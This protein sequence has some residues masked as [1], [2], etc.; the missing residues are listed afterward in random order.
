ME[1]LVL[2]LMLFLKAYSTATKSKRWTRRHRESNFVSLFCTIH[3]MLVAISFVMSLWEANSLS[4][5]QQILLYTVRKFILA[6]TTAPPPPLVSVL[7]Q[8]NS[9]YTSWRSF[10][11]VSVILRRG[12][13][14]DL[15]FSYYD[16]NYVCISHLSHVFYRSRLSYKSLYSYV[17][18]LS[19]KQMSQA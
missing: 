6:S 18:D 5:G 2:L 13:P 7:F 3:C 19:P 1:F 11:I 16:H 8:V 4:S 9:V 14:S 15:S 17:Y 12:L 10:L